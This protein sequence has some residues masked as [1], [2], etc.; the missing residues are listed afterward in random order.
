MS[1]PVL[2]TTP[3]APPGKDGAPGRSGTFGLPTAT[4]LVIGSV[5]GTGVFGLPT[6]LAAF[7]PISLVAFVLVTIGALALALTFGALS[8]RVRGS[9]GPYVYAREAFGE[10][11][12]F[13]TAWCY[14][15]TAWAGNAAIVV[16]LVGYA[17]VFVNTDHVVGW[18]IAIAM[19]GLWIPAVINLSGLRNMA[20]TQIVTTVLKFVPLLFMATVGLLFIKTANFGPFNAGGTS[21]GGA[22]SAAAAIALFSYIGI[23]TA[24]VAAGRVRDPKRNVGRATVLGTIGCAIVYIL[25]TLTVFGTVPNAALQ[26]S[27]APFTASADAIFGGHWAGQAVAVAAVVSGL[28]SLI[29]WTLIIG[30]MPLA[31][32]KDRLF[33]ERFARTRRGVP[34]FG[35]VSSTVL[36]TVLTVVSY[37]SFDQVFTTLVLL[38]VF[39]AVVPYLFSA[40]A[41]LYW[42]LARGKQM[43][44][45]HLVR[46]CGVSALALVFSFWALAGSGYQAVYYGVI[47]LL[48][49]LP[50]YIWLKVGYREY[51]ETP[52]VP[53]DVD[54]V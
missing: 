8:K 49:G 36:A 5:I 39:T 21:I 35:I 28:G 3:V 25:G 32:A 33:P 31:A 44:W 27:T 10:F 38:S 29:G 50:L 30:E 12:G 54:S 40:G 17:E 7:G 19:A 9:G 23:E 1:T 11:G 14:W 4:A 48:L 37:T 45:P 2:D 42:L 20:V 41:Q 52:T 47:C 51:G 13:L 43:R 6:A 26:V 15:I 53:A 16:A 46:D 34:V 18:S 22:I 24:S